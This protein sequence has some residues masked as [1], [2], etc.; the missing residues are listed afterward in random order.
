MFVEGT[1]TNWLFNS[2][3]DIARVVVVAVLGYLT[4]TI[5]I[6]FSGKRTISKMNTFDI[7][8]SIAIGSLLG[9]TILAKDAALLESVAALGTLILMQALFTWMSTR[10]AGIRDL[11]HPRPALLFYHGEL[12]LSTM[13]RARVSNE[14]IR[15]AVRSKGMA[16]MDEVDAVVLEPD[17]KLS[18][19]KRSPSGNEDTLSSMIGPRKRDPPF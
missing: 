5:I 14:D 10:H 4:F 9:R 1:R 16:S 12:F 8:L 17:G 15:E 19:V 2:W 3:E 6:R 11:V 18:I 7:I 13:H